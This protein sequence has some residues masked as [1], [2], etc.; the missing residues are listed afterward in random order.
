MARALPWIRPAFMPGAG[1]GRSP[2]AVGPKDRWQ[3]GPGSDP[4]GAR[5]PVREGCARDA[6]GHEGGRHQGHPGAHPV[7]RESE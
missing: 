5:D 2:G 1:P 6:V 7:F 3:R 4:E